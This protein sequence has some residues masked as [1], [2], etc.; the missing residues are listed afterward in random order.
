MVK[1]KVMKKELFLCYQH[2]PEEVEA[3]GFSFIRT[4]PDP[5]PQP[6]TPSSANS[7]LSK[8]FEVTMVA[9][10]PLNALERLLNHIYIPMLMLAG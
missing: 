3:V 1:K 8:C 6:S 2:I 10:K 4:S 9:N 5:I 7:T